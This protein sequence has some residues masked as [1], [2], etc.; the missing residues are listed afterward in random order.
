MIARVLGELLQLFAGR[1]TGFANAAGGALSIPGRRCQ[2]VKIGAGRCGLRRI[3]LQ[4]ELGN[5]RDGL[6]LLWCGH[7]LLFRLIVL[8]ASLSMTCRSL[9]MLSH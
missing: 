7:C 8:S 2:L 3:D 6:A 9:K 1:F 4:A 5:R